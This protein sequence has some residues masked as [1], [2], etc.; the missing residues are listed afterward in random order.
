MQGLFKAIKDNN[1]SSLLDYIEQGGDLNIK[2]DLGD[3]AL[4]YAIRSDNLGITLLFIECG[5][6]YDSNELI[7]F[8]DRI[9]KV[10]I[11]RALKIVI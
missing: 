1:L 11:A 8:A 10:N 4:E 7:L 3:S 6:R 2:N 9:N 5:A